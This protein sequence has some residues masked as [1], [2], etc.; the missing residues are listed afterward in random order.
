MP[1]ISAF[2]KFSGAVAG[3]GGNIGGAVNDLFAVQGYRY[4]AQ[5]DRAEQQGYLQAAAFADKEAT[6]TEWSTRIKQAQ[7]D[8]EIFKSL[9]E[10]RADVA[11]AG[12]AQ[13]GSALDILR[14][15]ASQG[16][17]TKAVLG[18]QGLIQE[19]GYR[20]Q[21]ASY[22]RM[23]DAAGMTAAAEDRA[24]TGSEWSA[25]IKFATAAAGIALAIPTGGTSLVGAAAFNAGGSAG[26]IY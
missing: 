18:E 26:A 10:T 13:S 4:K 17:L 1:E 8:R 3:Q 6:Y 12:F 11:G 5:G 9:G 7:T 23:A 16:A 25:G 24:A 20:E 19:E 2:D 22:R 15:S 14:E 21:A